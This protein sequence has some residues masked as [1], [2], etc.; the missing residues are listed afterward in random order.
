MPSR[1]EPLNTD[2]HTETPEAVRKRLE[3]ATPPPPSITAAGVGL[4]AVGWA[5]FALLY[6]FLVAQDQPETPFAFLFTGQLI[7]ALLHAMLSVPV[8]WGTVRAMDDGHWIRP[9]IAHLVM[10]PVYAFVGL[11]LYLA[12]MDAIIGDFVVEQIQAS[13][14]WVLLSGGTLYAVQFAIYH[15]VRSFQRLRWREKQASEYAA[16]AR[17]RE[18]AALKAQVH[19]HFLFNTLNSISSTVYADPE[20][21]REMIADL[22]QL[23]RHSLDSIDRDTVPLRDELRMAA[24]Y[25]SLESHR[26]SDRLRVDVRVK[27]P[28]DA[29]HAPVP[30][31]VVQ[32]LV[33]NAVKHGVGPKEDGGTIQLGVQQRRDR[34]RVTVEDNGVGPGETLPLTGNNAAEIHRGNGQ[35][36]NERAGE[37]AG[38]DGSGVGLVNTDARLRKVLGEESRL[39]AE[40]V[41]P[42]G[43]R[44][45]FDV[46]V[47]AE[48]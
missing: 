16:L 6:S 44:V 26:F 32:P 42:H 48:V 5:L 17:E 45:W 46:P 28:D 41:S 30:P 20:E 43:F 19:P 47:S 1:T 9:L 40:A 11:E 10:A 13:Y 33:E 36:E 3:E 38:A 24:S 35:R 31:M 15:L 4:S 22:A 39:H 21:A 29:L 25:L 23:L 34:L 8:W 2:V 7:F 12:L 14:Q 27:V 18:L 37:D